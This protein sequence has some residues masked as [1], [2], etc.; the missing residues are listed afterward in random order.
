MKKL[1]LSGIAIVT[2]ILAAGYFLI[3]REDVLT[4]KEFKDQIEVK[5]TKAMIGT[6]I[7]LH[8]EI[9]GSNGTTYRYKLKTDCP[10][11][12]YEDRYECAYPLPYVYDKSAVETEA[13][14]ITVK[15]NGTTLAE[16]Q[17]FSVPVLNL[18]SEDKSLDEVKTS[19]IGT[20]YTQYQQSETE[21]SLKKMHIVVLGGLFL[22]VLAL[23]VSQT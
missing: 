9:H 23:V 11:W 20:A 4:K 12:N 10:H 22:L 1:F 21:A 16:G 3:G 7:T 2:V 18:T 19:V 15:L 13:V 5:E 14:R 17:H 8:Q 6:N